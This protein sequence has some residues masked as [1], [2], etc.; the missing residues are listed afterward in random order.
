MQQ[1]Y[2][3]TSIELSVKLLVNKHFAY[4]TTVYSHRYS[5][6]KRNERPIDIVILPG[7]PAESYLNNNG[8]TVELT[9]T[10]IALD[11][12][13]FIV[14]KDN[15]VNVLSTEQLHDIYAGKIK[16]WKELEGENKKIKNYQRD[17]FSH[18]KRIMKEMVMQDT[19]LIKPVQA[20]SKSE[21]AYQN[22]PESI[23]YC[24]LSFLENDGYRLDSEIKI[25]SIDGV[26]PDENNIRDGTYP[27]VVNHYAVIRT[28]EEN[29][30]GGLFVEWILS[31]EGQACIREA[32][33]LP[34]Y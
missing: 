20:K 26:L 18:T 14:H 32:G 27:F 6:F 19:P 10:P 24:L 8:E 9:S 33:Y 25:L 17:R 22:F 29:D 11:A 12:L 1:N 4:V 21:A 13:V 31:D 15:P 3:A 34:L 30:N 2:G 23:G 5:D 16:N 28:G 7:M